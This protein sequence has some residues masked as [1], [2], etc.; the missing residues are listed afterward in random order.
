MTFGS[1]TRACWLLQNIGA[2]ELCVG[3]VTANVGTGAVVENVSY[4]TGVVVTADDK[5]SCPCLFLL[6]VLIIL[7]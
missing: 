5:S 6:V 2:F 3:T 4:R 7:V 1:A